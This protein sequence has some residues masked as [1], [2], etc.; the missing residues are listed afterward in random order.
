MLPKP[1][2]RTCLILLITV[3]IIGLFVPLMDND[4]AHHANIAL[5]LYQ[6]QDFTQLVDQGH[7]YLDKPHLH[8]WLA[9]ISYHLWGVNTFAYKFPSLL[10]TLMGLWATRQLGQRLYNDAVGALAALIAGTAFAF[11]LAV[12]DVRMD[13]ILT[14]CIVTAIW[15]LTA[16]VQHR[17]W[18]HLVGAALFL[19]LGFATKGMIGV[20]V[21]LIAIFFYILF[22]R[23]WRVLTDMRWLVLP[24]LFL[25]FIS[26]VLYC[27]YVQFDLHPEKVVRGMD[28]ISGVRFILWDQNFERLQGDNFGGSGSGDPFFFVHTFL[29]AFLPWSLLMVAAVMKKIKHLLCKRFDPDTQEM[30]ILPTLVVMLIILS[31]AGFKL[32]H[33]LN[34]LFP[35]MSILLAA[36]LLQPMRRRRKRELW[37]TQIVVVLLMVVMAGILNLYFFPITHPLILVGALVLVSGVVAVQRVSSTIGKTVLLSVWG[38]LLVN[39]LMNV[40]F[41]PE[42]LTHQAGPALAKVRVLYPGKT[43]CYITGCESSNS[44]AFYTASIP[45]VKNIGEL[46]PGMLVYTGSAGEAELMKQRLPYLLLGSAWQYPVSQLRARFLRPETR[47]S[48]L[49]KHVLLEIL[50]H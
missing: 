13:A 9:A 18:R 25:L 3:Y 50:P 31:L 14:A 26:P 7:D 45:E 8:F 11:V 39:F 42:V 1:V 21:P 23:D 34:I 10:F 43:V 6:H 28:H 4:A 33:Y 49:E 32:P 16:Y 38:S 22:R 19:A 29:W 36:F 37:V 27:Y 30:L 47:Q 2:Y 40:Q 35:L 17:Q 20:A 48:V 12:Q 5:Y 24:P 46:T 41:Y 15:Q 44:F